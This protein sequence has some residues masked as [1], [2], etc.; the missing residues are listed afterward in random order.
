MGPR[1]Q[2]FFAAFQ[3]GDS[4]RNYNPIDAHGVAFAAIQA[5]RE[6]LLEQDSR[7]ERLERRNADLKNACAQSASSS[8]P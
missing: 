6:K 8:R 3:L 7:I 2:D 4:D 5:L 1:A